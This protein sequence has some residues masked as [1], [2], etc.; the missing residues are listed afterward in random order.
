MTAGANPLTAS[1]IPRTSTGPPTPAVQ[2]RAYVN[3]FERLGYDVDGL[4]DT[5]G[6]S[7]SQADD[8]DA[9]ISC[10]VCG[11]LFTQAVQQR[12]LKNPAVRLAAE[13]SIGTFELLDYLI[14]TSE[15]VGE[16]LRQFARYV[17]LVAPS[18]RIDIH[19]RR[20]GRLPPRLQAL[21]RYHSA[22]LPPPLAHRRQLITP[23]A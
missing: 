18:L 8:P 9:L 13:T 16:G 3:A 5:I 4:L 1:A 22:D 23:H 11:A 15:T 12:R 21:D 10:D 17:V 20:A 7:R 2:F 6:F 19:V 14:V